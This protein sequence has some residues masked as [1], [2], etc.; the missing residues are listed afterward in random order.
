MNNAQSFG[1]V[2]KGTGEY[3]SDFDLIRKYFNIEFLKDRKVPKSAKII[4]YYMI[5]SGYRGTWQ[6][7]Y[8]H[9]SEEL[10]LNLNNVCKCVN[11]LLDGGYVVKEVIRGKKCYRVSVKITK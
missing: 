4:L 2:N 3:V 1:Y 6:G 9:L 8:R 10:G 11:V 5:S 7:T